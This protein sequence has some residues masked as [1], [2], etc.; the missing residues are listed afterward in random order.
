ML[1]VYLSQEN[2]KTKIK[3]IQTNIRIQREIFHFLNV[4]F[5]DNEDWDW[6]IIRVALHYQYYFLLQI[7]TYNDS[8]NIMF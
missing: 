1:D 6:H 8:K 3:K 7:Y 4:H 5:C 2:N